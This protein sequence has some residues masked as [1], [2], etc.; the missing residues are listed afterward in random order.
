[1]LSS[2]TPKYSIEYRGDSRHPIEDEIF[3][4]GFF[5][6]DASQPTY[7]DEIPNKKSRVCFSHHLDVCSLFP[8]PEKYD[9]DTWI[10]ILYIEQSK[11]YI[12]FYAEI[13]KRINSTNYPTFLVFMYGR[14]ANLP[15]VPSSQIVGAVKCNR[16]FLDKKRLAMGGIFRLTEYIPNEHFGDHTLA[17]EIKK[18]I[19]DL[20]G[21]WKLMP[22]PADEF[23]R[24]GFEKLTEMCVTA[25]SPG[26]LTVIKEF[27]DA[28]EKSHP[29][30][31]AIIAELENCKEE[32]QEC[33][34]SISTA[35]ASS[36]IYSDI[37]KVRKKLDRYNKSEK[38]TIFFNAFDK[39]KD[40]NKALRILCKSGSPQALQM[41]RIM[42]ADRELLKL[43]PYKKPDETK[44]SAFEL[45]R[46]KPEFYALLRTFPE[47]LQRNKTQTFKVLQM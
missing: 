38:T 27:Y 46:D 43:N 17:A 1:M 8:F 18:E 2:S 25:G 41:A 47:D 32:K 15:F 29:A 13:P 24:V 5:P 19:A 42:V 44:P 45:A 16:K 34:V 20:S 3:Q 14:E 12:D 4:N 39:E 36:P 31:E 10:Y 9:Q 28:R 35:A 7:I 22:V 30:N 37:S 33:T 23:Q 11:D 6:R 26:L 40:Y 21:K